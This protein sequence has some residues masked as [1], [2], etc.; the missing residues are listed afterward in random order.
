[1]GN[2]ISD[3]KNKPKTEAFRNGPDSPGYSHNGDQIGTLNRCLSLTSN[4][5]CS[6]M[7]AV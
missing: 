6:L 2:E 4:L 5:V 3:R 1:M 7:I